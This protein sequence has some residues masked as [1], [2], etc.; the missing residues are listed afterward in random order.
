[1]LLTVEKTI[2]LHEADIFSETPEELLVNVASILKEMDVNEGDTI[3][4][5]GSMGNS[6]FIIVEGEVKVHVEGHT[7][8]TLG[9]SEV[10]GELA[11]LD[12][13]PRMAS[14]T[15]L[16]D[17][18]LFKIEQDLLYELMAEHINVAK[19]VMRVLCQRLR[20]K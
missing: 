20:N 14:V 10:F 5:K 13:E 1:M 6:M 18:K 15:A 8:A 16:E 17:T 4:E 2:I 19:G 3:I 7:I 9:S 12:P 11:A